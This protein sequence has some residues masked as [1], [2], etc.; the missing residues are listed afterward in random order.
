MA[1]HCRVFQVQPGN[2][3]EGDQLPRTCYRQHTEDK[4][5]V[6]PSEVLA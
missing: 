4:M 2:Q 6:I 5:A 3:L 1:R